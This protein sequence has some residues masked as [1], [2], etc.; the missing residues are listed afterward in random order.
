MRKRISLLMALAV[1]VV[2]V[3]ASASDSSWQ[4]Q[5]AAARGT[6]TA[7]TTGSDDAS[8]AWAFGIGPHGRSFAVR[9]TGQFAEEWMPAAVPDV[10]RV[11]HAAGRWAAGERGAL[12][13]VD[14]AWRRVPFAGRPGA[15]TTVRAVEVD[16]L[17]GERAW[18]AG[19]E[20]VPGTPWRR[21]V[22]QRWDGS[23]WQA[24]PVPTGLLDASSELT[25][26]LPWV[27]GEVLAFGVDHDRSGDRVLVLRYDGRTWTRVPTPH[28]PGHDE[29]VAGYAPASARLVG[30]TA[31]VG[32]PP[33]ARR[34]LVYRVNPETRELVRE[35]TPA[36]A[37]ELTAVTTE[38]GTPLA[39]GHTAAGRPF[40]MHLTG[41][42]EEGLWAADAMP[43]IRGK[44]LAVSGILVP[45]IW[46]V[47]V[48]SGPAGDR[49]LVLRNS[50]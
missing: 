43:D 11:H 3:P 44:L 20:T 12:R 15:V 13:W 7:V 17:D 24:V 1:A 40:A 22:V 31:P 27:A 18:A 8:T 38:Y 2:P 6:F 21:G 14:G 4:P 32:A 39:V 23:H 30:W 45:N 25:A 10:G 16:P 26:V 48:A 9:T 29:H 28:R 34:P 49:P 36:V 41:D 35:R 37:A 46:A 47:G 50:P 42:P 19:V 5:S 33:S